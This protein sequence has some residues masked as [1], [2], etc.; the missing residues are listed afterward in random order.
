MG[1]LR[2]LSAGTSLLS[3]YNPLLKLLSEYGKYRHANLRR[4][5]PG[6]V[7]PVPPAVRQ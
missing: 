5:L 6:N 3:V 4:G 2:Q 1:I 7:L